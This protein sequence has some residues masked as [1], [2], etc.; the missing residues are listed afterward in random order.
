[1]Q[2]LNFN[3]KSKVKS[4]ILRSCQKTNLEL[5]NGNIIPTKTIV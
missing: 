4:I 5:S 2:R 3:P 1:V